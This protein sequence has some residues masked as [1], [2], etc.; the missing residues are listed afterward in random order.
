MKMPSMLISGPCAL[1]LIT[2][3]A[4]ASTQPTAGGHEEYY[5]ENAIRYEDHIYTPTVHTVQ[6]FKKGF[7]LAPA[8]LELGGLDPLVLRFDDFSPDN[9]NLSYTVVHC[10]ADWQPSDLAPS[11]YIN[12]M[13]TDFVPT[14]RQSFNTLQ[15]YLEY[16]L[17]FPNDMMQPS[18]SGNYIIK[19]YRNNDPEDLVLTR[20]FLVFEN[21][22]QIDAS[23]V[24]TRDI[25]H[26]ETDQQL[27]LNLRYPGI[28]VPDPFSDLKV[29]VLQNIRWD[30]VHTGFRPKFIRDAELIYDQPKEGVFPGGNEW[31]GVDLK[32]TRYSTLRVNQWIRADDGLEEAVLLPDDK[33]EFKVYL[34]Q[35]DINGKYLVQ[36]DQVKDDPLSADYVYVDFSLPRSTEE[37]GGDVYVY[38]AISDFQCKKEFRCTWDAVKKAYTLRVLVKQGYFDYAYA[39]LPSGSTTPDLALLEGSHFQT[40]N[41]YVVLVYVHDYPLGCDKLL[42]LRFLNSRKG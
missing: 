19:V 4:C 14:A 36:N 5:S 34:D 2:L 3:T 8:I 28:N 20:R 42:G 35:P 40:E 26:R 37:P 18:L 31:R 21:K 22:V 24:P 10:N 25:E 41:D 7:A 38:G 32:N 12:G 33:R 9:E 15:P 23:I 27:D 16:E 39:F 17:E 1:F 30:A 13:P 6:L 11:Q 29:A